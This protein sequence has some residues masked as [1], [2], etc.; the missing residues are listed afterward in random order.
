M[1]EIQAVSTKHEAILNYLLSNPEAKKGEVARMFGVTQ[2]WLSVII[3]S[4]SFQAK[5]KERQEEVFQ[6][7]VMLPIQDKLMGVAH[8]AAEKLIEKLPYEDDVK[9]VTDTMDKTL[10]NLGYGQRTVGTPVQQNNTLILGGQVDGKAIE[11]ARALVGATNPEI[12]EGVIDAEPER[13]GGP[14]LPEVSEDIIR[15]MGSF[16]TGTALLAEAALQES[17]VSEGTEVREGGTVEA[18][19]KI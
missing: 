9:V 15:E 5:L 3:H 7:A 4:S 6:D 11:R 13:L 16:G 10:K 18:P 12:I 2:S 19:R 8:I 1:P 17:E 14:D